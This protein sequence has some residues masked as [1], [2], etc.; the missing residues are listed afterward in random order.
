MRN[1]LSLLCAAALWAGCASLPTGPDVAVMPGPGKSFEQFQRDDRSCRDYA[2]HGV[3]TDP[4]KA[5]ATSV[6]EGAG[7]G[8]G[9]GAA[10]G[11]VLS[12]GRPGGIVVGALWGL[13]VGSA[14]GS[15]NA[16]PSEREAQRR[17][18]IG[19]EQCMT[20]KGNR[21]P[22]PPV[23]YYR[24]REYYPRPVVVYPAPPDP[25]DAS[26]PPPMPPP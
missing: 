9:A 14:V 12:G 16:A 5:G 2:E 6:A 22:S 26:G 20:S 19:Y 8:L 25:P 24:Y 13:I 11:A 18:D 3:G 15:S 21:L 17:Y 10:T 1:S 23:T 7:V 4:G